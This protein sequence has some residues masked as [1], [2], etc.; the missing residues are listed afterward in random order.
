MQ[1]ARKIRAKPS[2]TRK[3]RLQAEYRKAAAEMRRL[4]RYLDAATGVLSKPELQLLL[5]FAEI[6]QRK[7]DRLR[8]AI[9]NA[10]ASHAA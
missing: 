9:H 4:K 10:S 7:C 3:Q 8:R 2:R 5:E 6:A 1:M